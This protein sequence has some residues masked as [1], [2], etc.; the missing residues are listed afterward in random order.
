MQHRVVLVK[1]LLLDVLYSIVAQLARHTIPTFSIDN[2][3]KAVEAMSKCDEYE[4]QDQLVGLDL[5]Y[6]WGHGVVN[7]CIRR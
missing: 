5:P 1:I 7:S 6:I 4:D 2:L 3:T